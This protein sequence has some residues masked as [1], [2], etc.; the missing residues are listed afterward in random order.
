[1][2]G[3]AAGAFHVEGLF[4]TGTEEIDKGV[5]IITHKAAEELFVM[6]DKTSEIAIRLKDVEEAQN[7]ST[8]IRQKLNSSELEILPWQ[9]VSTVLEQWIE[10]DNGFIYLIVIVVMIVV[11]IGILNTVLMGVLERT[12]EFGT[13]YLPW[14]LN[15]NRSWRWLHGNPCFRC[16]WKSVRIVIRNPANLSTWKNRN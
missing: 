13:Y 15:E 6:H 16:Y 8:L 1:M 11:A 2:G 3:I 7:V 14:E 9:E 10:F 12:R 4:D 5:V